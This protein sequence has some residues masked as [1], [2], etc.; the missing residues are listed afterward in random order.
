MKKL[1]LSIIFLF[2]L[3]VHAQDRGG[4]DDRA[5]YNDDS[6]WSIGLS[7]GALLHDNLQYQTQFSSTFTNE[8]A[9]LDI[10]SLLI[11]QIGPSLQ[12]DGRYK[13]NEGSTSFDTSIMYAQHRMSEVNYDLASLNKIIVFA[14]GNYHFGED[15]QVVTPYV[16]LDFGVSFNNINWDEGHIPIGYATVG[17]TED[18]T[19]Q[20]DYADNSVGYKNSSDEIEGKS[21][22][23]CCHDEQINS[24]ENWATSIASQI[25]VG[26]D[27][28][29]GSVELGILYNYLLTNGYDLNYEWI[30]G[31]DDT[32]YSSRFNVNALDGHRVE[33]KT[34]IPFE[35]F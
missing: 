1:I 28:K 30:K 27:F 15:T 7:L 16:A 10:G 20:A 35:L 17:S 18:N 33:L 3:S 29:L 6:G 24:I 22:R 12:I 9:L 19:T 21:G 8:K 4:Y 32:E 14:G 34:I 23:W 25:G 5:F 2:V 31:D 11:N 13:P 26:V